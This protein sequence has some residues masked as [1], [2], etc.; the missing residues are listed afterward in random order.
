MR[1]Q[2]NELSFSQL[3]P[4]FELFSARS[5][6]G[7]A[8]CLDKNYHRISEKAKENMVKYIRIMRKNSIRVL[9]SRY[10]HI[11]DKILYFMVT[12]RTLRPVYRLLGR[13]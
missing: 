10:V 8:L 9:F 2:M 13:L 12:T 5:A 6:Y 7:T 4:E 3:M 11:K 1:V